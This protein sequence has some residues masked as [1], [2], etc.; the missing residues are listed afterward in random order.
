[1]SKKTPETIYL[2]DYKTPPYLLNQVGLNFKLFDSS[3][4]VSSILQLSLN[5]DREGVTEPLV[6]EGEQLKLLE[7]KLDGEILESS[8]YHQGDE[9]LQINEV[10]E[11]F[12]LEIQTQIDPLNNTSLE[13]LYLTSGNFCT[14]CEAQGFRRITYYPDRPDVLA[15]L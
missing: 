11:K 7:V 5:P 1:M 14:Q 4:Q 10:P 2:K 15:Q 8:Q 9:S 12:T 13:G 3:T 6:L